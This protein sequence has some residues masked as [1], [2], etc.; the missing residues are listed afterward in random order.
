MAKQKIE[1]EVEVPAGFRIKEVV[2]RIE[3]LDKPGT[4]TKNHIAYAEGKGLV[5]FT[6]IVEQEPS[7]ITA[8]RE[9]ASII[10]CACSNCSRA[11]QVAV[12]AI[13]EW[14]ASIK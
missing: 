5:Y 11:S 6:A 4:G 12:K 10:K 3:T 7:H 2:D 1:V 13:A 9:I 8:F 14:E